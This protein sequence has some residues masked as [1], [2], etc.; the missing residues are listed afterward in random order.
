MK[1]KQALAGVAALASFTAAHAQTANTFYVTTGWFRFMP[2]DS[3]DPL[4]IISSGGTPV[5]MA[6]PNTGANISSADTLGLSLGYYITDHFAAEAELGI[7]PKFDLSGGGS[8]STFGKVGEAK[9]WSPA[10][11]LKYYFNKPEAK[12]RPYL[13]IGFTYAWFTDAH[14][15]NAAFE[16]GVLGGPTSVSTDRSWAPVFNLGFNYNFTKHWFAGFSLSYIP[17]S[18]IASFDTTVN[19]QLSTVR[20]S[21]AKIHLN[22]LVTYLKVG[23]N[24]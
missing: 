13:G 19:N 22:P 12:F 23:Y 10:L 2:Q 15:T 21:E 8:F 3:S 20:R 7:P 1:L 14:I 9:L 6:I 17:I 5:N 18:V 4:K 11:L 24:F 16:Q